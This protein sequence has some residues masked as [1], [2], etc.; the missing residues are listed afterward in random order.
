[1]STQRVIARNVLWN[2]AGTV[3]S[4]LVGFV[5]SPF[6][7]HHLGESGYGLWVLI[8]SLTG[9]FGLLDLGMRA[10]LGRNVAFHHARGDREGVNAVVSTALLFLCT[11]GGISLVGMSGLVPVFSRVFHVPPGQEAAARVALMVAAVNLVLT[12]MLSAFDALLWAAQRFDL[13][14]AVDIT[15]VLARTA[16]TYALIGRG[17]GVAALAWLTLGSTAAC[18]AAKA[19]ASFW[20]IPGL[21]PNPRRASAEAARALFSYGLWNFVASMA[22]MMMSQFSNLLIGAWLGVQTVTSYNIALRLVTYGT[23]LVSAAAGVMTPMATAFHAGGEGDRQ[24]RLFLEGGKYCLTLSLFFLPLFLI[25]GKPFITLW[26][27]PRFVGSAWLLTILALGESV[28]MSQL[29]SS[30][31]V[32]GMG[33]PRRLAAAY[34]AEAAVALGL[35]ATVGGRFGLPGICMSFAAGAAL[36]RGLGTLAMASR[37]VGAPL[38]EYATRSVAPA[39]ATAAV[40]AAGL[41]VA[42]AWR[43]PVGWA[44]LVLYGTTYSAAYALVACFAVAYERVGRRLMGL[45]R[46]ATASS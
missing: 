33:R 14:N 17:Y 8:A 6:L 35:A 46:P 13:L 5:V 10:S 20:A 15:T 24:R 25:L 28:P 27:G 16:L 31:I 3:V 32:L 40:P 30:G 43:A 39:V 23:L 7:V 22:R 19:V 18:G 21:R 4:M 41:A 9:Y 2:W 36:C 1:M 26:M 29:I 11:A 12:F 34:L 45:I 42:V 37:L 38:R 44:E